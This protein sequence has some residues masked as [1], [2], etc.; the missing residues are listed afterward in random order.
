VVCREPSKYFVCHNGTDRDVQSDLMWIDWRGG[1]CATDGTFVGQKGS[2]AAKIHEKAYGYGTPYDRLRA[3]DRHIDEV[4]RIR[5]AE[6]DGSM[7]ARDARK[8]R[9]QAALRKDKAYHP[10]YVEPLK[11]KG[12]RYM[13]AVFTHYG[14]W[15]SGA[16]GDDGFLSHVCH[17]GGG[18]THTGWGERFEHPTKTWACATHKQFTMQMVAVAIAKATWNWVEGSVRRQ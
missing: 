11:V 4:Q 9:F 10:G 7:G 3:V 1:M 13:Q 5:L 18:E 17:T 8:A 16:T 2:P 15:H 12:V 14:G 6:Q